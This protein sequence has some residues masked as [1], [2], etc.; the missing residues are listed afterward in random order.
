MLI[1]RDPEANQSKFFLK[2]KTTPKF[3]KAHPV[4]LALQQRVTAEQD[5][6]HAEGILCP[7]KVSDW[8]K[9]I[10]P[11]MKKDGTIRVCGDFKLTVNQATQTEVY[12]FPRI[13]ELFASLSGGTVFSTLDFS[14]AYNQLLLNE[15]AQELTTINTH[16]GLYKYIRLPFGVVYAPAIFE[17]TMEMLLKDLPMTCVYIDDILVA[18][19]MPQ[20][21][22]NNLATVLSRLQEA[23]LSSRKCFVFLKWSTWD[24]LSVLLV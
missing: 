19:K 22:L 11:V 17:Q 16:K 2:E 15:K 8:A 10:V 14:H 1:P 3:Y 23:G 5:R 6:L 9:P 18:G 24:T 12:P 4:P 13:D 7:I 21:H 20:D